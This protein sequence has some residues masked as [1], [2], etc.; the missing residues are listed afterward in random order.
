MAR[1]KLTRAEAGR[2]GGLARA[3]R[4]SP[5]ERSSIASMGGT[6]TVARYGRVHMLRLAYKKAGRL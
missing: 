1:K 6:A 2:M 5:E 3:D 4:L